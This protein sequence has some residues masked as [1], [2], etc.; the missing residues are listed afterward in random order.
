[1]VVL[2]A[3]AGFALPVAAPWARPQVGMTKLTQKNKT[4]TAE[5]RIKSSLI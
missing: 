2:D 5:E 4:R 1:V 3:L